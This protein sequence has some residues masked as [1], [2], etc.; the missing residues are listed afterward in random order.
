MDPD[1]RA[2][3]RSWRARI[4]LTAAVALIALGITGLSFYRGYIYT[5]QDL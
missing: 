3:A 4:D 1:E 5:K 2:P